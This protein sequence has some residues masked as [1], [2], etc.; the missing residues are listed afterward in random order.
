ML[1]KTKETP[2]GLSIHYLRG[3]ALQKIWPLVLFV[4]V[5][6]LGID[7]AYDRYQLDETFSLTLVPFQLIGL[8]LSIFLGFRNNACYDRFWEARKH[9]GSLINNSRSFAR[10]VL[11]MVDDEDDVRNGLIQRQ[12]AFAHALRM[13]LRGETD[14]SEQLAGLLPEDE[15]AS[16]PDEP[17]VPQAITRRLGEQLRVEWKTGHIDTF[18]L[19][20]LE[21]RVQADT[22]IQG[23]CERI[24]N[25]P[26][27]A[28]YTILT[29]RIVGLYC[30]LLPF[31]LHGVV[32]F[33]T[34]VVTMMVSYAF[35]GL[36][37]IGT[38]IEDPFEKDLNDLPLASLCNII[39]RDLRKAMGETDLPAVMQPVKGV[40][41]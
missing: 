41:H 29:H 32:G 28:S 18:H 27:P 31:G 4:G 40:L 25:T 19:T 17:N 9:W 33:L 36:D 13:H 3:S 37:S 10:G 23:A 14:W 38:E 12:L 39:E 8:A 1:V 21:A 20:I 11:L 16:L 2:F 24:K 7:F 5:S 22:D 30:L 35:F 15:L 26:L 34:P 6:S